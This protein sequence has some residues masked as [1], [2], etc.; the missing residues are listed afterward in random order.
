MKIKRSKVFFEIN[1]DLW[2]S[3]RCILSGIVLVLMLG[4][5]FVTFTT[6]QSVYAA[7]PV[8]RLLFNKINANYGETIGKCLYDERELSFGIYEI[9]NKYRIIDDTGALMKEVIAENKQAAADDYC[10]D[11]IDKIV[12]KGSGWED[13]A[14]LDPIIR[15]FNVH[16]DSR[17]G[18][19][20]EVLIAVRRMDAYG[21]N[22]FCKKEVAAGD[23]I[24]DPGLT[25]LNK[26]EVLRWASINRNLG[27]LKPSIF[28]KVGKE[29]KNIYVK[30]S[31][32]IEEIEAV[33]LKEVQDSCLRIL[34]LDL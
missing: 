27:E 24:N 33:T 7:K 2:H 32:A 20:R 15:S 11:S 34:E 13:V 12:Y 3:S 21:G 31:L 14:R 17:D 1:R 29:E 25:F 30:T 22:G 18:S 6:P 23:K 4:V 8:A 26:P 10:L 5:S 28:L 9:G 19:K 16:V